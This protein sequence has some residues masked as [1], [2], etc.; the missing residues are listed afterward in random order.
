M[1]LLKF[2]GLKSLKKFFRPKKFFK[3]WGVSKIK[4]SCQKIWGNMAKKGDFRHI[5]EIYGLDQSFF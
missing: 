5:S 2:L 1:D 3:I 4:K